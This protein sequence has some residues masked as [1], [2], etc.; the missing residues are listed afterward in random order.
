MNERKSHGIS[1]PCRFYI[2]VLL[3]IIEFS[4]ATHKKLFLIFYNFIFYIDVK[5]YISIPIILIDWKQIPAFLIHLIQIH[6]CVLVP[7]FLFPLRVFHRVLF[8]YSLP[9]WIVYSPKHLGQLPWLIESQ[10]TKM[11]SS[12]QGTIDQDLGN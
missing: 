2:T 9:Q 11:H 6:L 4:S 5:K 3:H 8:F 12:I 1:F 10:L 7:K